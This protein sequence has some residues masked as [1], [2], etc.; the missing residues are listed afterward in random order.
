MD[1]ELLV[2]DRIE[3]GRRLVA[4]LIK[5]GFDV[6]VAFW[7]R[8]SE[9]GLWFLYVGSTSV[10]SGKVGDAYIT[11]YDCLARLPNSSISLSDIKLVPAT[12]PIAKDAKEIRD[13]Y[14]GRVP[15]KYHGKQLGRM[16]IEEAY[17]YPE[18]GKWF[19]GFDEIKEKFPTAEAFSIIVPYPGSTQSKGSFP[20]GF[21]PYMGKINDS[22][23]EGRAAGTVLF[24]GPEGTSDPS[25]VELVFVHR[26]EGWNTVYHLTSGEAQNGFRPE[27]R[28]DTPE[29]P[30]YESADFSQ[31]TA[32]KSPS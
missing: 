12:N 20:R 16:A 31:F 29:K 5:E 23:F 15:T 25:V 27:V 28:S 9:E 7:V 1:T 13:R 32:M 4:E 11:A 24:M 14:A 17:I 6:T 21:A 26:P 8:T 19:R 3:D 10:E 2:E 30:S 18:P 22:V